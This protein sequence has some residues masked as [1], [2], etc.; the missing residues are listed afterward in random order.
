MATFQFY[1]DGMLEVYSEILDI[2]RP[3]GSHV[4]MFLDED[5]GWEIMSATKVW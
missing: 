3:I 1:N 5:S 4:E 2:L